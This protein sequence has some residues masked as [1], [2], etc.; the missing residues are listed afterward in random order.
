MVVSGWGRL[1]LVAIVA[2][3]GV[4]CGSDES[5]EVVVSAASSLTRVMA[6]LE[7]QFEANHP[8]VDVVLNVAA[9]SA[10]RDQVIE[11][12]PV[13]VFAPA[14]PAH[15][16]AVRA[17]G[18]ET[19][20][21]VS[22]AT[23]RL[24]LA[25]PRGNP[26]RVQTIADLSRDELLVGL[27]AVGVPCGDLADRLLETVGVSARVDT[28]EA[29]VVALFTKLTAGELDV[30]LVYASEVVSTSEVE[31]V[32]IFEYPAN[33]YRVVVIDDAHQG[34]TAFAAFLTSDDARRTLAAHGFGLP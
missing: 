11:G 24:A 30:G 29:D 14:D 7:P 27:C 21:P 33:E 22:F 20:D 3:F 10:L 4:A 19:T 13:D 9:S 2:V 25:V 32:E 6:E 23:N 16:E 28:R 26:G 34:A 8:G 17:A 1:G 5:T 12:A 31:A 18:I 15:I